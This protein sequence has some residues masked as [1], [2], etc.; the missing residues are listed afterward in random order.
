MPNYIRQQSPWV[1]AAEGMQG[2]LGVLA[3]MYSQL[4]QIRAQQQHQANQL[5]IQ[6]GA[7][8]LQQQEQ[9]AKVPVY[10]A[11]AANYRAG[12]DKDST[13]AQQLMRGLEMSKLAQENEFIRRGG[14]NP[15][16]QD[17]VD[18]IQQAMA[19]VQSAFAGTTAMDPASSQRAY[20]AS[21]APVKYNL[22]QIGFDP[23]TGKQVGGGLISVPHGNPIFAPGNGTNALT[24]L[25]PGH[26]RPSAAGI[27]DP[28]TRAKNVMQYLTD[29]QNLDSN[30]LEDPGVSNILRQV[31]SVLFNQGGGTQTNQ[32]PATQRPVIKSI[33]QIR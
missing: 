3:N 22:N 33:K 20:T 16:T 25:L 21:T 29:K 6:Q 14:M 8:D 9:L 19:L 28:T 26:F 7:L 5:A 15:Q 2:G 12:A 31:E 18:P 30:Q 1:G 23:N 17:P 27:I 11:Q 32:A 4:P 10:Q 13:T 24:S